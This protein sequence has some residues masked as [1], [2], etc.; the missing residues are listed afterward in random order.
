MRKWIIYLSCKWVPWLITFSINLNRIFLPLLRSKWLQ[1]PTP[2]T[3]SRKQNILQNSRQNVTQSECSKFSVMSSL[4]RAISTPCPSV[5][6]PY[7]LLTKEKNLPHFQTTFSYVKSVHVLTNIISQVDVPKPV[8]EMPSRSFTMAS[9]VDMLPRVFIKNPA[10]FCIH[11]EKLKQIIKEK[12]AHIFCNY[13][14]KEGYKKRKRCL[15]I[16]ER[17]KKLMQA[18]SLGM[19]GSRF[20]VDFSHVEKHVLFSLYLIQH[21]REVKREFYSKNAQFILNYDP[22]RNH[23][24]TKFFIFIFSQNLN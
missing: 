7:F 12:D 22:Y 20:Q 18:A 8:T 14:S 6:T 10:D 11:P 9:N 3:W 2:T 5:S 23:N 13:L 24:V 21:V 4:T 1:L 17:K 19:S 15:M 16:M